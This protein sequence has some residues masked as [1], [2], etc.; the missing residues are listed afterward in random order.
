MPRLL[1]RNFHLFRYQIL[2]V[3]KT[4][5]FGFDSKVDSIEEA[6]AQKNNIFAEIIQK[7]E[8]FTHHRATLKHQLFP[9]GDFMVIKLGA[10]RSL[11]R[12]TEEFEEEELENWPPI[13][14]G[15][16]NNPEKQLIAVELDQKAFHRSSTVINII[17]EQV[18]KI[19]PEYYLTMQIFPLY[20]KNEFWDV[21]KSHRNKLRSVKFFMVAPNL[22]NISKGLKLDLGELKNRTNSLNTSLELQSAKNES[23]TLDEDDEFIQSLVH[24]TSEGGGEAT[25]HLGIKGIRKKYKTKD[26]IKTIE[27]DEIFFTGDDAPEQLARI[28]RELQK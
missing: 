14:I 17:E 1:K 2:P 20:D 19:L 26:S 24:Y 23:L 28:L 8:N 9:F 7:I 15:I 6:I 5:Q 3:S 11:I 12:I 10:N 18:N 4:I 22:S 27:I 25:A 16:N 13:Y 21:V